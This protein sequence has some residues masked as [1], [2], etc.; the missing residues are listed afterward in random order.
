MN[1][2]DFFVADVCESEFSAN[3]PDR[4]SYPAVSRK[5]VRTQKCTRQSRKVT[6]G[7]IKSFNH[8]TEAVLLTFFYAY[9]HISMV[10]HDIFLHLLEILESRQALI[11]H[12]PQYP[13]VM[14]RAFMQAFLTTFLKTAV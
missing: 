4:I 1:V 11:Y 14:S 12:F 3:G 9:K 13:S 5:V 8:G 7:V 2:H 10:C 6:W